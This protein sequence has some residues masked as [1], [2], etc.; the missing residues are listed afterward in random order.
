MKNVRELSKS[1]QYYMKMKKIELLTARKYIC[2]GTTNFAVYPETKCLTY[3]CGMYL[4][5]QISPRPAKGDNR[6]DYRACNKSPPDPGKPPVE[7]EGKEHG[8][9]R[10]SS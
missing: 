3:L 7:L 2:C 1:H 8:K 5:P 10:K 6:P 9:K 4:S